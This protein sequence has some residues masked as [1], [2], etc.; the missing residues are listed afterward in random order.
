M[1]YD[2]SLLPTNTIEILHLLKTISESA[3]RAA[4]IDY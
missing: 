4:A 3:Y 2:I 1:Y